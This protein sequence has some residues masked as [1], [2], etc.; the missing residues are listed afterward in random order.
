M[1]FRCEARGHHS[2]R[3]YQ[4]ITVGPNHSRYTLTKNPAIL[5]QGVPFFC[6]L[7]GFSAH[8]DEKTANSLLRCTKTADTPIKDMI[9]SQLNINPNNSMSTDFKK[10][11]FFRTF[12]SYCARARDKS[13]ETRY[14]RTIKDHKRGNKITRYDIKRD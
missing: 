11:G 7:N 8:L 9:T 5:Y 12:A 10:S 2:F 3:G 4:D 6:N 14:A 13:H 1:P